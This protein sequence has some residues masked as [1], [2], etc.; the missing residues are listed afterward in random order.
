MAQLLQGRAQPWPQTLRAT[1]HPHEHNNDVGDVHQAHEANIVDSPVAQ[2]CHTDL[3]P[4]NARL[5]DKH[6]RT[7]GAH[8]LSQ[9]QQQHCE[10]ESQPRAREKLNPRAV[11][12]HTSRGAL[13]EDNM[14]THTSSEGLKNSS[15]TSPCTA[16]TAA[17]RGITLAIMARAHE[18]SPKSRCK[19]CSVPVQLPSGRPCSDGHVSASRGMTNSVSSSLWR[20][21]RVTSWA[22]STVVGM[23][24][25]DAVVV[26]HVMAC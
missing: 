8:H 2:R 16:S 17:W 18:C 19:S 26:Q 24:G 10:N 12:M 9:Q 14:N 7:Q 6:E 22:N 21:V 20:L 15:F 25:T 13:N 23:L 1:H 3:A 5:R 4:D 11:G